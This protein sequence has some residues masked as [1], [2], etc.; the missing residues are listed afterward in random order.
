MVEIKSGFSLILI[1]IIFHQ[2]VSGEKND[3]LCDNQLSYFKESL[4]KHEL[5]A[6]QCE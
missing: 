4:A 1:Q 5:W 2:L 6:L 3:V